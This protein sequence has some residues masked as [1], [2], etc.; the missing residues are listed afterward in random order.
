MN[1]EGEILTQCPAG[2][3]DFSR[4]YAVLVSGARLNPYGHMLLN[5][6][7]PGGRYFHVSDVFGRPRTMTE[8]EFQR[9]L[10][11]NKKTIVSVIRVAVSR[12]RDSQIK[13]EQLLSSNWAW[14]A[15]MHNCET[16]VEEIVVAGGGRKLRSGS[17]PLPMQATNKCEGW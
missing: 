12:P 11:S 4:T 15:I 2:M 13:L 5:T 9:Y 17:L 6:G 8:T 7:G 10:A 3:Y 14:G 16:M 1:Y